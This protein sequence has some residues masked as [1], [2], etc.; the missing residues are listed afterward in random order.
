MRDEG[1]RHAGSETGPAI[2]KPAPP[3]PRLAK[4]FK[5]ELTRPGPGF[6]GHDFSEPRSLFF[7]RSGFYSNPSV[8]GYFSVVVLSSS[9][10]NF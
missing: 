7:N 2:G 8:F 4:R 10:L 1:A 5:Q 6:L 3:R 9:L